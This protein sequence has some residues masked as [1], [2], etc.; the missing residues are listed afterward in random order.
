MNHFT[1]LTVY[2]DIRIVYNELTS[3]LYN[4]FTAADVLYKYKMHILQNHGKEHFLNSI[5]T[6]DKPDVEFVYDL[7]YMINGKS[8]FSS[9]Y[10]KRL[11]SLIKSVSYYNDCQGK[12]SAAIK[13]VENDIVLAIRTPLKEIANTDMIFVCSTNFKFCKTWFMFS[14]NDK[15]ISIPVGIIIAT[16]DNECMLKTGLILWKE[17]GGNVKTVMVEFI[18]TLTFQ[19]VFPNA[20]IYISKFHFLLSVWKWLFDNTDNWNDD[21]LNCFVE[22]KKIICS[23]NVAKGCFDINLALGLIETFPHFNQFMQNILDSK[24]LFCSPPITNPCTIFERKLIY[25]HTK[26]FSILQMFHFVIDEIDLFYDLSTNGPNN[27]QITFNDLNEAEEEEDNFTYFCFADKCS[28]YLVISDED[29]FF[30]DMDIGLCSCTINN[31]SICFNDPCIHQ[32]FLNNNDLGDEITEKKEFESILSEFRYVSN[33][34]REQFI[35]DPDYF[36]SGIQSFVSE[37]TNNLKS[38]KSLLLACY[39]LKKLA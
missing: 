33:K 34:I 18:H 1:L 9:P 30:V 31:N 11:E 28:M 15:E 5:N 19:S 27:L 39:S 35:T 16:K 29:K 13:L 25:Y 17:L 38:E 6:G 20:T 24:F 36:K 2:P 4:D 22:L 37:L 23:E 3:S 32:I 21:E 26:S 8:G 12:E 10:I 7:Y 14:K